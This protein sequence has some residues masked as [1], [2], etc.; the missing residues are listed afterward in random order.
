MYAFKVVL[1]TNNLDLVVVNIKSNRYSPK[2]V[3]W[4]GLSLSF[5]E[6]TGL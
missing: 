4:R 5:H 3:N 2:S 6:K 1:K